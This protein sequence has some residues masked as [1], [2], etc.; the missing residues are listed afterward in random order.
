M[1]VVSDS[2]VMSASVTSPAVLAL[3][4]GTGAKVCPL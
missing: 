3:V 2:A 4:T 1:T